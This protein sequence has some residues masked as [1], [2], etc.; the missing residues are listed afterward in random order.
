MTPED[1]AP[2]VS[3]LRPPTMDDVAAAAGVSRALV[4]LVMRNAPNVSDKRRK[5][6]LDAADRLGY[7]PNAAA[8]SLAER[9]SHTLG[10]VVND[11]H[12]P[13][14]ADLVDGIHEV[15]QANGFRLLLNTAWRTDVDERQA[16]DAFLE[17]R[18]D[19]ILVLG[20]TT[21]GDTLREAT[22][23][24]PLVT[25]G[26]VCE[27]VDAVVNDDLR[28]GELA[29]EHLVELGHRDIV[30]LD[31]GNGAGAE[32]R[33]TG[34]SGVMESMGFEVRIISGEFTE[35]SGVAAAAELVESGPM[36]TAVFAAND[37]AAVGLV[38]ALTV[39]GHRVPEAVS[40]IG[41]D[42]TYLAKLR[43]IGLTTI[44]QPRAEM[45]RLA[46]EI[47]MERLETRRRQAVC[48]VVT[49]ELVVRSTTAS[50]TIDA[51]RASA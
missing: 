42:N 8:R 49:P 11:L 4:S 39:A 41:Y 51:Q 16:I 38:D 50:P 21:T 22:K 35:Q 18:V 44:N 5:A 14:F 6:V 1:P 25:I 13:F 12:N 36:P 20:S 30:H 27:G 29:A 37:L 28:G 17:Y 3:R 31:G 15:A 32:H 34:F 46:A 45:G 10:V 40:V 48:H 2:S 24:A 23:N 33:R 43:H 19:G 9:R 7:R 47:V 26:S